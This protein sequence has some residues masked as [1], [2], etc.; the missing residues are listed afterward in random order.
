MD[1]DFHFYATYAALYVDESHA[2]ML[3]D[4]GK[5]DFVPAA[6]VQTN[7]EIGKYTT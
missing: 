7:D 3:G 4:L 2:G 1:K 5:V 6:T